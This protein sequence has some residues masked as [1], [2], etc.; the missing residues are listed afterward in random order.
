MKI[1][2]VL[3]DSAEVNPAI[4]IER[5]KNIG[6]FWGGWRTWRSYSTDNVVCHDSSQA[7]TISIR[8]AA[9][10]QS[11]PDGFQYSGPV[12]AAYRQIGNAVPPLIAKAIGTELLGILREN[13]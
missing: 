12:G 2:W 4:E 5:L 7:R 10:L 11:F 13:S 3:A 6:P 1:T 9:R 8:E